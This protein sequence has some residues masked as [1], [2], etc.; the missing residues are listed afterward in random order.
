MIDPR[1][2]GFSDV[3]AEER[4]FITQRRLNVGLREQVTSLNDGETIK[5]GSRQ[6]GGSKDAQVE[7]TVGLALSGGGLRSACV[8]L[9][10]VQSL[11]RRGILRHVDYLSTVSGG[12]YLGA[13]LTS[14]LASCSRKINWAP[15]ANRMN[16]D[17]VSSRNTMPDTLP[18]YNLP[19]TPQ[20]DAVIRLS[21]SGKNMLKPLTF[22]SR[23]L[24]G[25]LL[26]NGLR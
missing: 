20:P 4:V 15:N 11:Y 1:N 6:N 25:L 7:A 24:W 16:V 17:N 12:G 10:L 13:H 23:H 3:L 19:G 21:H 5:D 2:V 18:F 9:G 14:F 8:S 22:L 26:V